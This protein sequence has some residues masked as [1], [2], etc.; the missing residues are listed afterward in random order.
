MA[1][2]TLGRFED[3]SHAGG[4]A[5]ALD[6][7]GLCNGAAETPVPTLV[8]AVLLRLPRT[9]AKLSATASAASDVLRRSSSGLADGVKFTDPLER[10]GN[11]SGGGR[12]ALGDTG[13]TD[14]GEDAIGVSPSD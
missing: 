11:A 13:E 6:T 7:R 10:G 1:A 8:L 3:G 14:S 4:L 9:P 2:L 5:P 12:D